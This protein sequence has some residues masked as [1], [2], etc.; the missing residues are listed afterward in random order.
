MTPLPRRL[1][2]T[3]MRPASL[4]A[5]AIALAPLGCV[6]V[7]EF[8]PVGSATS[9]SGAWT[10]D[11][12]LPTAASCEALGAAVVRVTFLDEMRPVPHGSLVFPCASECDETACFSSGQVVAE[13]S[14]TVRLEAVS[15][16]TLVAAGPEQPLEAVDGGHVDLAPAA[17]YSGRISARYTISGGAP[18]FASCDAAGI[19]SVQLAFLDAGGVVATDATEPCT[20]GGVGTRVEPG[21]SY[22]VVLRALGP[23]GEVV[24]ETEPET[25]A[26]EAGDQETLREGA[27]IDL[28]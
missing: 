6:Q 9:V 19:A 12:A 4:F 13:G 18:S 10:I 17:F 27:V 8:R 26:I 24:A 20:V 15:G 3:A 28:P 11:G 7:V 5:I 1:P 22:T 21:A 25:F 2:W 14:W 23:G 16:A